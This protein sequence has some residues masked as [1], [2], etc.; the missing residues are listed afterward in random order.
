LVISNPVNSTVPIAYETLKLNGVE[1]PSVFGVTTLDTIRTK[2][3]IGELKGMDPATVDVKVV[4][5]HS[6]PTIV[7]ILS[8]VKGASFT[9]D[10]AK[11]L[12]NRIQYGGDEVVKAKAGAG[13]ATLSMAFAAREFYRTIVSVM[14]GAELKSDNVRPIA[15]VK[16]DKFEPGYFASQL[17]IGRDGLKAVLDLPKMSEYEKE[18]LEVATRDLKKDVQKGIDFV[19]S[20]PKA[21]STSN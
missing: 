17:E 15:F 8:S 16:T 7:P 19:H 11:A 13:S 14:D 9:S 1:K 10:E 12:V 2:T 5:G 20:S 18:L 6:G 3:F 4:G 21:A